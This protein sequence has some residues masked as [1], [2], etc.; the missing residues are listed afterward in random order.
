MCE[1]GEHKKHMEFLLDL[2]PQFEIFSYEY[3]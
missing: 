1:V 2:I 3:K